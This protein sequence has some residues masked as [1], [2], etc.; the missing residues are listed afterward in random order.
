MWDLMGQKEFLLSLGE[1]SS[2]SQAG[3]HI[4]LDSG[5]FPSPCYR[6]QSYQLA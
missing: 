1:P 4:C 6:A 5:F 3:A 2:Q